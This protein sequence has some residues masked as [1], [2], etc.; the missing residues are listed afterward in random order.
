MS[1]ACLFVK[2]IFR[3]CSACEGRG[4]RFPGSVSFKV[5]VFLNIVLMLL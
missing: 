1:S 3:V 2:T 4:A 5:L